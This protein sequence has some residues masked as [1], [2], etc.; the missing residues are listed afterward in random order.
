[1]FRMAMF[2]GWGGGG[3]IFDSKPITSIIILGIQVLASRR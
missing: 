1:M 2:R 3:V